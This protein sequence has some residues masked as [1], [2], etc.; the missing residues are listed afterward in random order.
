MWFLQPTLGQ[1]I[2]F[3]IITTLFKPPQSGFW[4]LVNNR[5]GVWCGYNP[6]PAFTSMRREPDNGDNCRWW[7]LRWPPPPCPWWV[8][9]SH[10]SFQIPRSHLETD[11]HVTDVYRSLDPGPRTWTLRS[12]SSW[13]LLDI[14]IFLWSVTTLAKIHW[15]HVVGMGSFLT[16]NYHYQL[17]SLITIIFSQRTSSGQFRLKPHMRRGFR[18]GQ[19][20]W[21]MDL[22][23]EHHEEW[24]DIFMMNLSVICKPLFPA[25]VVM[26]EH[27]KIKKIW[28][29]NHPIIFGFRKCIY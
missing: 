12:Q 22:M 9:L 14:C 19:Q 5:V 28:E 7:P 25:K 10:W 26:V 15:K 6:R 24:I 13:L 20:L 8:M 17:L 1:I 2:T 18:K 29:R 27:L 16:L 23:V 4:P 3:C 11:L 21:R